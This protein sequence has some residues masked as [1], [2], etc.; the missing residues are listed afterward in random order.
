MQDEPKRLRALADALD[1]RREVGDLLQD[2]EGAVFMVSVKIADS[3]YTER[4]GYI[5]QSLGRS[6][7]KHLAAAKAELLALLDDDV[8]ACRA[9]LRGEAV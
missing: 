9:A 5:C 7:E 6:L 2:G 3:R 8:E 4:H 1:R